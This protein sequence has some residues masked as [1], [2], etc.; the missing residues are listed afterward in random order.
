MSRSLPRL[1]LAVALLSVAVI[2]LQLVLMQIL[3]ITQWHHFAYMVI[4]VALLGFGAAG[5]VLALA[6]SRL[7]AHSEGLL[8]LLMFGSAAVMAATGSLSQAVFG[9][10]DSFLL[11]A[12]PGQFWRLLLGNLFVALPFFLAALAIGLVFVR[13]VERIG[14]FYFANLL[15]SGLGGLAAILLLELSAPE[16]LPAVSALFALAAGLL[17]V[18]RRGRGLLLAAAALT[19]AVAVFGLLRPTPLVLSQYKDLRRTLDL[20]ATRLVAERPGALGLVQ[21]AAG[22]AL[23]W[24]PGLS[25]A[26][27]GEVP[28]RAAVFVNGNWF[29]P[30]LSWS[31]E[32]TE[33]LLD[34]ST[35]ALPYALSAPERVLVLHAGTGAEVGQ[36]LTRGARRVV[37][38]EPHGAVAGLLGER[39]TTAQGRLWSHPA[40]AV[41]PLEPRTQLAADPSRYDLIVLPTI[42]AFGGTA[43]LYALQ[44]QYLFTREAFAEMWRHLSED[45]LLAVTVWM[46]YP[47]RAPFR[48]AATLVEALEAAG[49]GNPQAHLAAM[50][51]WGTI[52]FCVSRSPLTASD[53]EKVQAFGRQLLFDPLLLPGLDAAERERFNKL[54][55]PGFFSN[56]D[57]LL[58]PDREQLYA[59]YDF[60][61][62]PATDDRPFFSQF[63]RW[64]SLPNLV[65]LFGE[66]AVPFLETGYLIVLLTF[67]QML[68]AA[69]LLILL[70][71]FRLGWKGGNRLPVFFYFGGLAVGYMLVE[72]VL[73]HR[74]VLYL[75]HPVYAAAVAICT[76]LIFSGAGSYHS[77]GLR[78]TSATPR[79]A[80][81][82]VALLLLLYALL[83]PP[84]LHHTIALPLGWK[85]LLTLLALAPPAFAMGFPF[86]LGLRLLG[87]QREAD[88]PWAWGINGC[89]SVL[90]TALATIIAVEAGFVAV[91]ITAAAAYAIA[92][93]ARLRT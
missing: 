57:R 5:S 54:Q 65:Q 68:L 14:S 82:L 83:L 17:I 30:V 33:H 81:A 74:F 15:G 37:A 85:L 45:G 88:V 35:A 18:P 28:V 42:G 87:R 22:P 75:G 31:P 51:S 89:L 59:D 62:R 13:E 72:I 27:T 77:S 47:P 55:D 63:L 70:P 71:L 41:A 69:L 25:L 58:G 1:H 48:L 67:V 43:G 11:F 39:L 56:L 93:L 26:Y 49:V 44:E 53:I 3:S 24:A 8:P 36:A 19:A 90:S 50:R 38:V 84:L 40:V 73:I 16:R 92:A 52:T 61:L 32:A 20:P 91:Q 12:D 76:L 80:A 60:R 21:A 4:S 78:L 9:G 66:R 2:A 79:R 64:Q 46:D 34:Y 23:R 29:G 6:R 7:L 10:F 86:P